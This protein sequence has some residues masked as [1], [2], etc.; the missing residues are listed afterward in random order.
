MLIIGDPTRTIAVDPLNSI[1]GAFDII[2]PNDYLYS[3][4]NNDNNYRNVIYTNFA[5]SPITTGLTEGDKIIFYSGSSVNSPGHEIIMGDQTTFSSVSEGGRAVA[6]AALTT[7]DQVLAVGDLTFFTEPY[8]AVENNG[9]LINNIADFLTGGQRD[10]ELA[11]FPYFFNPNVDIVFDNSLVFNSQFDDAVKLKETLEQL[12]HKVTFTDQI[13]Q[14]NDVIFIG[15]FDETEAV[16]DYL[17]QAKITILGPDDKPRLG[18]VEEGQA[19]PKEVKEEPVTLVSDQPPGPEDRFV[20]GRIQV[21][22][23]GDLERG[24]STLFSLSQQDGRNVLVILSDNPDTNADAFK[25]LFDNELSTCVLNP[26]LAVCQTQEPGGELRP[27]MRRT[28]IDN[29]LIV[30]DDNGRK[31]DDGQTSV[32]EYNNVLSSTYKIDSWVISNDGS[33]DVDQLL[34]YDAVIWT[35]GDFWD[36]SINEEDVVLLTRYLELGGNLI[37]S[38]AS[39]A[40]DWD[41]TDFLKKVVHADYLDFAEQKDMELVLPDHPIA[42]DFAEDAVITF[43]PTPSGEPLEPDVVRHTADARVIFQRGPDS[44]QAGAAAVIAYEDERVKVAYY[45]FPAYLL[46][47]EE[48]SHL[49]NNTISWFTKKPLELPAEDEYKPF[50]PEGQV[51]ATPTEEPPADQQQNE[52][53]GDQNGGGQDN[54]GDNGDGGNSQS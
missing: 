48:L 6:A 31:R 17:N 49:V 19:D 3:L 51:E 26:S 24:G 7:N 10:Y 20:D 23:I 16:A 47:P 27:S 43:L 11:D 41:H 1:A 4:E 9:A 53:N 38:G 34:E 12:D 32:I 5:D 35:T 14:E 25:L 22:G 44:Q 8:S 50:E 15:R 42:K 52:Q 21:E 13:G 45:A 2:Y 40:F 33:P 46:P 39:I 37:L 29:I 54:G 28:R 18:A 36:D 30:S